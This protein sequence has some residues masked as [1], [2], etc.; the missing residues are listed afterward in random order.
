MPISAD[1]ARDL[2]KA[3]LD[4]SHQLGV[5]R[6]AN[7]ASLTPAQRQRIEDTE[8]DLLNYSSSLVTSAVGIALDDMQHDLDTITEATA[9]AKKAV[10]TIDKV[11]DIIK[12]ATAVVALGGAIVS[13]NPKAI[14][15][16]AKDL[17]ATTK[18]LAK[19]P[20]EAPE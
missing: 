3:F 9:K 15:G 20:E 16:A 12:V 10:E 18:T 1:Q 19:S 8:W 17:L 4:V 14:V 6:F 7:W 11:K 5:F 13:K 2:A